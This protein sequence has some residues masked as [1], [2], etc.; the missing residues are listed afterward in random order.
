M[1]TKNS[2][3]RYAKSDRQVGIAGEESRSWYGALDKE[4]KAAIRELT[5]LQPRWNFIILMYLGIWLVAAILM[6]VWPSWPIQL[7][8]S[9]LIGLAIHGMFNFMHEG[10]HGNLFRNKRA[11][12]AI[13]FLMGIPSLS[14]STTYRIIHLQHHRYNRTE[15]DPNEL[16]NVS[17]NKRLLSIVFYLALLGGLQLMIMVSPFVGWKYADKQTKRAIILEYLFIVGFFAALFFWA[18]QS[19]YLNHLWR[20]WGIP[21]LIAALMGN[22]RSWAEHLLTIPGHPLTQSRTVTSNKLF[23]FLLTNSNYHLEHHLV[24][25]M[26]WYNLP[27]LHSLMQEDY[28]KAGAFNY[29]SYWQFMWDAVR[30]GVHGLAPE[31]VPHPLQPAA[32]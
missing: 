22:V 5:K 28:L 27:K 3:S 23:S 20:F 14:S 2:G 26:P 19:G 25:G 18:S 29:K 8:G 30:I 9:L 7:A 10:I 21:V 13:A 6:A 11:D 1:N 24:P 17:E 32:D 4:K 12:R 15:K 31:L 16:M